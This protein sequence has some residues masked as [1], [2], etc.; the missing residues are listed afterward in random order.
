M[1]LVLIFIG[2]LQGGALNSFVHFCALSMFR[3]VHF[4]QLRTVTVAMSGVLERLR[5][6]GTD[7]ALHPP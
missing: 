4:E 5:L 1:L 7:I 2:C 3:N 6:G